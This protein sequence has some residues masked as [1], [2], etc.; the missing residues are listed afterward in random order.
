MP[1]VH[2]QALPNMPVRF[3]VSAVWESGEVRCTIRATADAP[4]DQYTSVFEGIDCEGRFTLPELGDAMC[5]ML[6][7][8]IE[9]QVRIRG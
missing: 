6:L 8:V 3:V 2:Q 7:E 9:Q 4:S 1:E 5:T